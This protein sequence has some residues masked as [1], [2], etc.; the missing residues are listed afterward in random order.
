MKYKR[1]IPILCAVYC[2][3]NTSCAVEY[4]ENFDQTG[5]PSEHGAPLNW[6]FRN[7][8]NPG[9]STWKDF[10]PGN[11]IAHIALNAMSNNDDKNYQ[12]IVAGKVGPGHRLEMR[13][14]NMPC[15]GFTGHLFTYAETDDGAFFDEIDIEITAYDEETVTHGID[16]PNGWTDVRL[17]SWGNASTRNYKPFNGIIA[18][19]KD[20]RGAN[21]S[22]RDGQWHTYTID[23]INDGGR[24]GRVRF[25]IDG[26]F[27]YQINYPVPDSP[28]D[29]FLGYRDLGWA[30]PDDPTGWAGMHTME[31]DWFAVHP[32]NYDSPSA[33]SDEYSMKTI[34]TLEVPAPGILDNDENT[35]AGKGLRAIL[36]NDTEHGV[37]HLNPDGSFD[38]TPDPG[39]AGEDQFVYRVSNGTTHEQSNAAVV[40]INVDIDQL[41]VATDDAYVTTINTSIISDVPGV[42]GNDFDPNNEPI[43]AA[44][45]DTARYGELVFFSDGSFVYKPV[46]DFTGTD[47]FTYRVNDGSAYSELATVS[48]DVS[49]AE[50]NPVNWWKFDGDLSDS[51]GAL[52]GTV[53]KGLAS[54]MN[55]KVDTA[56]AFNQYHVD[57]GVDR[58]IDGFND[59]TIAYW[60]KAKPTQSKSA[61]W[62][63]YGDS[64]DGD[65]GTISMELTQD[66]AL[67]VWGRSNPDG[68]YAVIDSIKTGLD[69]DAWHHIAVTRA[70]G[71]ARIYI[72]GQLDATSEDNHFGY[73]LN[74]NFKLRLGEANFYGLM[75]DVQLYDRALQPH[76]VARLAGYR[77]YSEWKSTHFTKVEVEDEQVSGENADPDG[78]GITNLLEYALALDP[79]IR[80]A[81]QVLGVFE[82]KDGGHQLAFVLEKFRQPDVNLYLDFSADLRAPWMPLVQSLF[83]RDY[84]KLADAV[85]MS[86][87][88]VLPGS[89]RFNISLDR[90][91]KGFFR[92]RAELP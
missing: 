43:T 57:L 81:E 61:P 65:F 28:S 15:P 64:I 39:F 69:D 62:S 79:K 59:F 51:V 38:F 9:Q 87:E 60:M 47:T 24:D 82:K 18:P 50:L 66:G 20:Y 23:W 45:Q 41:P 88:D 12:A 91:D 44:L 3:L 76:E 25:Y 73:W 63:H 83:G 92:W 37:L 49:V 11:G 14:K 56:I 19:I 46:A 36:I 16:P 32:I 80:D 86:H 40:W 17:N 71:V 35:P 55:G 74:P 78:D 75:D 30:G 1:L 2:A 4:F 26:V 5:N 58:V 42:M 90:S 67:L 6:K 21:I 68:A 77:Y 70:S 34:A 22:H 89:V 13:V 54:F 52:D 84:E 29:V 48:I 72:D 27:Q 85:S 33:N 53:L 7:G 8:K 10:I 31:I